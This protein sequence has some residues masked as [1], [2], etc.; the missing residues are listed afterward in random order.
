[1]NNLKDVHNINDRSKV[2][3]VTGASR[4]IG[5]AT[6]RRLCEEGIVYA[7]GLCC[8]NSRNELLELAEELRALDVKVFT[9]YG[10]ISDY[11]FCEEMISDLYRETGRID[12]LINNAAISYV[13]L[14]MDMTPSDWQES[15]GVNL[16][17]VFN[18][19]KLVVPH[20]LNK[21]G[22]IINVSSVWGLCGA[23]MEVCYSAT[24]GAVNTFTKALAKEL[25]LSKISVNAI[26]FGAVDTEMNAHLSAE[27][28]SELEDSIAIGRMATVTEAADTIIGLLNMPGYLTGE[29][30]KVD[31]GWI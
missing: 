24:K 10:D 21:G 17:S 13:G 19:C 6:A 7:I 15:V 1:M 5:A 27:E 12:I 11:K 3:I 31:G 18:T 30:I 20:M 23:S 4:G 14:L 28:K 29:V 25:A 2:A 16:N 26:A 8:K 22:Q 9:Y